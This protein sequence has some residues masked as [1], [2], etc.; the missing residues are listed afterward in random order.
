MLSRP[1]VANKQKTLGIPVSGTVNSSNVTENAVK[2]GIALWRTA[3]VN[4]GGIQWGTEL[5]FLS[6]RK[7]GK[8][9]KTTQNKAEK[10]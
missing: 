1:E 5:V 2:K 9:H 7:R 6:V 8:D 10:Q 4:E 3:A